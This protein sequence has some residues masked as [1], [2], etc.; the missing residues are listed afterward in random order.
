MPQEAIEILDAGNS[1][2]G[3]RP[4]AAIR[5]GTKDIPNFR[6]DQP[7][8]TILGAEQKAWF[9]NR[10]QNSKATWKI[11]GDTVATL[12]MRADPQN[13]PA[14]LTTA[15]PGMGYA[16]F[17]ANFGAGDHSAAYVERGEIYD[18]VRDH[19]I[20]GFATV[21]GDRHSF[22]A[23]LAAKALPPKAFEPV[24]IAFVTGS[25]SAPGVIE[26]FEHGFPKDHPLRLTVHRPRTSRPATSTNIQFTSS[27]WREI[28][29][30][31]CQ[32]WRHRQGAI[33][34]ESRLVTSCLVR[35][36][37]RAWLFRRPRYQRNVRD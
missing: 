37:G 27:S 16:G 14:G 11:W 24:G 34:V 25:I 32:E 28:V 8:Q 31:V 4:P 3:G 36:Y 33:C 5:Y 15:W 21:A 23:G 6:R 18:F 35:G 10:L 12:E 29:P 2:N 17:F 7:P 22:W 30:G 1:Y 19:G 9:L 26:S 20:T 13:L